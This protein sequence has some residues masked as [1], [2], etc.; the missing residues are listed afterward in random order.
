M[1]VTQ[2]Q[3]DL[4]YDDSEYCDNYDEVTF[5]KWYDGY[6]KR[7]VQKASI[8]EELLHI[9][10]LPSRYWDWCVPEDEKK[11]TKK[12]WKNCGHKTCSFFLHLV[13]G[14]KNFL[15]QNELK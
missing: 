14:Y 6:E 5:F 10:W 2:E 3:T 4:W 12:L 13:T 15:T 11:E 7:K 8:K 1:F 9:T